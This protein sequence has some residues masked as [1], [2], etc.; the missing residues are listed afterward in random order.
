LTGFVACHSRTDTW[1]NA[2]ALCSTLVL[3][4]H[5]EICRKKIENFNVEAA[6]STYSQAWEREM[7]AIKEVNDEIF[8]H[9]IALP[10]RQAF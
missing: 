2:A 10:P 1:G 6:D 7:R 5:K 8:K 3:E 9:L 4:L